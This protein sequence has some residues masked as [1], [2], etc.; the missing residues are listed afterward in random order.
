MVIVQKEEIERWLTTWRD[1]VVVLYYGLLSFDTG[2]CLT[3]PTWV[4]VKQTYVLKQLVNKLWAMRPFCLTEITGKLPKI[5]LL[6]VSKRVRFK[7]N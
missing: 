4:S 1:W 3:S 6:I 7:P 2:G 5:R